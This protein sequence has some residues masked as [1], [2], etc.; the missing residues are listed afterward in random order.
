MNNQFDVR[1]ILSGHQLIPV[2]TFSNG[3]DPLNFA[4]FLLKEG[5]RVIEVTLRTEAGLRAIS[6]IKENRPEMLVGAGTVLRNEQLK[7]LKK[8]NVDFVISPG[9]T[10][11]L[12]KAFNEWE[13]PFIPGVA[14]PSEV[15]MARDNGLSTLKFFPA[16]MFGGVKMLKTYN[17]LFPDV[18]FCPTGGI[19]E[20]TFEEYLKLDNVY[21]VGGSW[22][23][24]KYK[25]R[26]NS[27]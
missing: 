5:V 14:T 8:N 12:L 3:M 17:Q 16:Q 23:Q 24:N 7:L 27:L 26:N 6:V 2:V 25:N 22:L 20:E 1:Q 11:S 10:P 13:I 21:A 9:L 15:M 4:D 18:S 19:S